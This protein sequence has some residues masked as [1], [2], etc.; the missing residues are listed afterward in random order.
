MVDLHK[1]LLSFKQ[2]KKIMLNSIK[3][4][5]VETIN[6][7]ASEGRVLAEDIYSKTNIPEFD[8]SAV[9]GFGFINSNKMKRKLK[10]I[11]ESKPGQPFLGKLK[12]NQA[13][14]VFTGAYLLNEITNVDTVCM[15]E[16]T[17]TSGDNLKLER[18][19]KTGSNIRLK[20]ED[21]KKNRKVFNA[22][23]KIR[24]L[25]LAQLSSIGVKKLK[26]YKKLRV[27][28]FSSGDELCEIGSK[29]SKY[30]IYD[31]NK[32]A[33]ISLF[34]KIGCEVHDFGIVKDNYLQTKQKIFSKLNLIDILVTSGGVSKSKTDMIGKFFKENG[35]IKF[36]RLA[37]K[38]GRP[39]V[40]GKIKNTPFIGL[41]GNPVAAVITFFMLTIDY[42]K[43]SSGA[44]ERDI[45]E[46]I[47]PCD[48]SLKKK[49]GRTEW[50]RGKIIKKKNSLYLT[51]FSSTGSGIISSISQSQG[52]I[53]LDEKKDFIKKGTLL[54]FIRYEDML[55]WKSYILLV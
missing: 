6:F 7:E 52:I 24:S 28:I 39:F 19:F 4:N 45:I 22:G 43:V 18:R 54:K 3:K 48:F 1:N 42:V 37:I 41:P 16:D 12:E 20:G 32:L 36:W 8:N 27:G 31:A 35:K 23:R 34:K 13:I 14:K 44:K 9:D 5:N 55:N 26:V 53:E 33:L 40:F 49:K 30:Q 47:L 17:I 51:K 10:I 21:V 11:G 46:R 25:D 15:E 38:P 50:L 29:K 2:A